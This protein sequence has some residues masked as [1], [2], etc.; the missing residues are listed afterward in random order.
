MDVTDPAAMLVAPCG[1]TFAFWPT[2]T[3]PIEASGT[4]TVTSTAP[5]PTMTTLLPWLEAPFTRLTEPTVPPI[6][7]FRVAEVRSACAV[8][9]AASALVTAAWSVTSREA[10][11][12]PVPLGS[13]PEVGAAA[14]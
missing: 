4:L 14:D 3:V 9:S 1:V 11:D 2:W 5:V 7:D 10:L 6:E 8:L 12:W 13:P